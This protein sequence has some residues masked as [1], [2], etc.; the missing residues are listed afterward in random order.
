M[1]VNW[2]EIGLLVGFQVLIVLTLMTITWK[3]VLPRLLSRG[4]QWMGGA[5][6]RFM[7]S[8]AEEAGD[9]AG[10]EGGGGGSLS[11]GG[12]KIDVRTLKELMEIAPEILAVLRTFGLGGQGG[13]GG[14][15]L[16][17]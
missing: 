11:L 8:L 14:G 13:G 2:L 4:E 15:K 17:L 5:I 1:A 6:G 7:Q 16:G 10:P 3:W 12:F 9:E